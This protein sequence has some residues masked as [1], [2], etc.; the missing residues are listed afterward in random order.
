MPSSL[1]IIITLILP[2]LSVFGTSLVNFLHKKQKNENVLNGIFYFG[3]VIL[4]TLIILTVNLKS[5]PLTLVLFAGIACLM[6]AVNNV[7][8]SVVPL[9][10]RDKIDS[11][12]S[13][14]L[15]NTFCYVGSTM[16]TTLLGRIADTKG[17]NNVFICILIFT[18]V[19][20][21]V[22]IISSLLTKKKTA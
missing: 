4:T 2:V 10:S 20:C 3:A 7:I 17:W 6:A 16:S 12:L 15:L 14:G 1:S 9:Y 13:A 8:T 5:A 22:C 21:F 18:A 19:S 11:G